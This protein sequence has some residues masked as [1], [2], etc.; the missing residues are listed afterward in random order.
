LTTCNDFVHQ[1]IGSVDFIFPACLTQLRYRE[2]R[3]HLC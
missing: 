3:M 1:N 2:V